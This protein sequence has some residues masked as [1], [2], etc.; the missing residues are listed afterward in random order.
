MSADTAAVAAAKVAEAAR[1]VAGGGAVVA[2]AGVG[3]ARLHL[4]LSDKDKVRD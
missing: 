4:L 2:G 3:A 1:R